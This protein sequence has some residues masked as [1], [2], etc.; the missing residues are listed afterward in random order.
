MWVLTE[1]IAGGASLCFLYPAAFEVYKVT[2]FLLPPYDEEYPRY[3]AR[4]NLGM[5]QC[6]SWVRGALG[7][8]PL[9][10]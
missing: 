6:T 10:V 3:T 1:C 5:Q 2:I 8:T 4:A 7:I 9:F